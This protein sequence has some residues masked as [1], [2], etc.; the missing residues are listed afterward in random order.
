MGNLEKKSRRK[1]LQKIILETVALAGVLSVALVAPN[2]IK[3]MEKSGIIPKRRQKEYV[4]SSA[5]KLAKRGLLYFDGKRYQL[6]SKGEKLLRRWELADFKLIKPKRWDRK[7]RLIIFDIPEKKRRVRD[8]IRHLFNSSGLYR[9][10]DSV[11]AYP[12]DC[13]DIITLLKSELGVGKNVLYLIVEELENDKYLR[14]H[15]DLI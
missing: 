10:Q 4:S 2:V 7:W 9:L 13:E 3:S 14:E 5:S 11:W 12:Y 8:Q 6:T 15:F 1:D